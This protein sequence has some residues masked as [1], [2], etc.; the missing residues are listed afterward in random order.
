MLAGREVYKSERMALLCSVVEL[1]VCQGVS[2][3]EIENY[4]SDI[5]IH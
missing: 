1:F 4:M 5:N 2:P 3:D